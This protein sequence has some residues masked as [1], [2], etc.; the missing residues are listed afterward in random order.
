[1]A[2]ETYAI[3]DTQSHQNYVV[4]NGKFKDTKPFIETAR[5]Q[6]VDEIVQNNR[7]EFDRFFIHGEPCWWK[8]LAW[9]NMNAMYNHNEVRSLAWDSIKKTFSDARKPTQSDYD[10]LKNRHQGLFNALAGK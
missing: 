10:E 6:V 1:M 9:C 3:A 7:P 2:L 4:I 5:K 8:K